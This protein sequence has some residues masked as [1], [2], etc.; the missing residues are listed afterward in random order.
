MVVPENL[1]ALRVPTIPKMRAPAIRSTKPNG[2][3]A[4]RMIKVNIE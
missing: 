2:A 3:A 1:L 4:I